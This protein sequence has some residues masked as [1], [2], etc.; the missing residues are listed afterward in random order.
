MAFA[1]SRTSQVKLLNTI[2]P[3]IS[4]MK[5]LLQKFVGKIKLLV[6]L[7]RQKELGFLVSRL[8]RQGANTLRSL[9]VNV[10]LWQHT[11]CLVVS[12]PSYL[13]KL[14]HRVQSKMSKKILSSLNRLIRWLF[15]LTTTSQERK[16]Q[17]KWRVSSSLEKPRCFTSLVNSKILMRCSS[18][19]ITKLMLLR[20]GLQNFT[21]HLG[22]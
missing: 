21:R 18:W 14:E 16:P 8:H 2:T 3:P 5:K 7:V 15:L 17:R 10:M 11:N 6:G 13:L 4:T 20:G 12:G 9:K 19:V 1:Q 22:F